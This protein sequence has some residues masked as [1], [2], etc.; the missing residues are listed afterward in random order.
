MIATTLLA[1]VITSESKNC[2]YCTKLFLIPE[3]PQSIRSQI[4]HRF[5]SHKYECCKN[6]N[7]L[8]RKVDELGNNN[9]AVIADNSNTITTASNSLPALRMSFTFNRLWIDD[10]IYPTLI[11]E[12]PYLI[13]PI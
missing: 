9:S 6:P 12:A 2:P 11:A 10:E 13:K 5:S 3:K 1:T 4:L 8:K 7:K